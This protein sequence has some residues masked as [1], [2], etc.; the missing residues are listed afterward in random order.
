L[1]KTFSKRFIINDQFAVA[2]LEQMFI[3]TLRRMQLTVQY[4]SN[5]A[6]NIA[7]ESRDTDDVL[8]GVKLTDNSSTEVADDNNVSNR[9]Y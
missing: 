8:D 6:L 2:I 1:S 4:E 5:Q 7:T 9:R 3:K